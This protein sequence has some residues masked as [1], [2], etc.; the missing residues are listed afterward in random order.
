M[1]WAVDGEMIVMGRV[2]IVPTFG[3]WRIVRRRLNYQTMIG[4]LMNHRSD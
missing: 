1:N 2:G 4:I 3:V